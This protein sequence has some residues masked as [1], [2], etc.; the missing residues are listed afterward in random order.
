MI[1]LIDYGGGNLGSVGRCLGRLGV[2]Y[3]SVDNGR[4]LRGSSP[5]IFPGVGS[6]GSVMTKVKERGFLE[7]LRTMVANGTPYLG[8]CIG[9]QILFDSSEESPGVDGLQLVAGAVQRFQKGKVPQIGWNRIMPTAPSNRPSGFVYFVNSYYAAP[10]DNSVI[11]Y[12]SDYYGT[13]CAAIHT[14]SITAYQFHPEKSGLFGQ[15]LVK[16]WC[17]AL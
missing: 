10:T 1:D 16:E 14:T 9:M 12:N 7:P 4:D 13:F 15:Q 3:R 2:A 11:S 5:I 17:D 6:F 8:L